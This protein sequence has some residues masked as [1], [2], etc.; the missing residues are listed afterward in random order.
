MRQRFDGSVGGILMKIVLRLFAG[1]GTALDKS[2]TEDDRLD[3][4]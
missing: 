2:G 1:D 3:S 4:C